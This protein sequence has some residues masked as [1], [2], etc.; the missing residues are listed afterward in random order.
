MSCFLSDLFSSKWKSNSKLNQCARFWCKWLGFGARFHI[1]G[2]FF[3][4]TFDFDSQQLPFRYFCTVAV[5][6]CSCC[7]FFIFLSG[8]PAWV[9]FNCQHI[10]L[11]AHRY[12]LLTTHYSLLA[13][14]NALF[15]R[16]NRLRIQPP[17]SKELCNERRLNCWPA[18]KPDWFTHQHTGGSRNI[19]GWSKVHQTLNGNRKHVRKAW[20]KISSL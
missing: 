7:F 15:I 8:L 5:W 14:H 4:L 16:A 2:R 1:A 13:A 11:S 3:N 17:L 20:L 12:S 10:P 18:L 9:H 19:A 6:S